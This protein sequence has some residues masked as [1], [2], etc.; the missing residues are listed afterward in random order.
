MTKITE[1]KFQLL[2]HPSCSPD[3]DPSDFFLF[4]NLKKLLDGQ[5]F[6]SNEEIGAQ[7]D[8]YFEDLPKGDYIFK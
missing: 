5:R 6:T 2:Q 4:P 3:L 8:A 7:T 1:L